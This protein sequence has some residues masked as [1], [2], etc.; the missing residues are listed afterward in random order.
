MEKVIRYWE[1]EEVHTT[2]RSSISMT[3]LIM[4][5]MGGDID[6]LHLDVEGLDDKLILAIE[7]DLLPEILVYENENIGG[8]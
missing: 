8:R 4:E 3:N 6:W 5:E 2:K 7:E 1:T